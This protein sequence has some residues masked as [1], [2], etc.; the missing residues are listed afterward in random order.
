[1]LLAKVSDTPWSRSSGG[2]FRAI[3]RLHDATPVHFSPLH[4]RNGCWL[5][6]LRPNP[7][8][9]VEGRRRALQGIQPPATPSSIEPG[10]WAGS[11]FASVP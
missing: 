2:S 3:R 11:I 7:T 5:A 8:L 6:G 1:M 10:V 4:L 9:P